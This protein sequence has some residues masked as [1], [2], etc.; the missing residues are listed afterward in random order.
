VVARIHLSPGKTSWVY[1]VL[2]T[3]VSEYSLLYR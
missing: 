1:A 3:D 2:A